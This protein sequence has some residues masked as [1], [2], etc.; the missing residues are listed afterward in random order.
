MART[1]LRGR[2]IR[3]AMAVALGGSTFQL[4]GC[5]PDVRDSLLDGL[6]QT[7]QSLTT[8][9]I[10]AFFLTL[11]DESSGGGSNLTTT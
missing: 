9:L 6:E 8:A 2:F 7:T 11:D 3:F 1:S 10:T 4:S 5:D